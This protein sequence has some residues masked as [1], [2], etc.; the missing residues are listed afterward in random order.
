MEDKAYLLPKTPVAQYLRMSTEHQQYSI[1]N[2]QSLLR[3][4]R[5]KIIWKSCTHMMMQGKVGFLYQEE[6]RYRSLCTM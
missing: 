5:Q 4:M 2:Q 1:H 3:N 6:I